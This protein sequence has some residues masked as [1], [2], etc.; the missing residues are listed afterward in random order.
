MLPFPVHE[1]RSS[2]TIS[3]LPPACAHVA[4][5]IHPYSRPPSSDPKHHHRHRPFF[6]DMPISSLPTTTP[7]LASSITDAPRL[8]HRLHSAS[9]LLPLLQ[10]HHRDIIDILGTSYNLPG[11]VHV[12]VTVDH[13][14]MSRA[15][16]AVDHRDFGFES[17]SNS[18]S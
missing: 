12:V 18:L 2:F 6:L 7:P 1:S 11:R 15:C 14:C 5:S 8:P 10:I 13:G 17:T 3:T 16:S 4:S 9:L